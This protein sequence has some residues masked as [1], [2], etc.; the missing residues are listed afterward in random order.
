MRYINSSQVHSCH[1]VLFCTC[2]AETEQ[3]CSDMAT[4]NHLPSV[5]ASSDA[6]A[7]LCRTGQ[8]FLH[9]YKK[10]ISFSAH[11]KNA[12]LKQLHTKGHDLFLTLN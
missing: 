7:C 2:P 5:I 11:A 3:C 9:L 10:P 1:A 12:Q 8:L 6:M 4:W